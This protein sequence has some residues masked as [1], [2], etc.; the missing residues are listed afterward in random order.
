MEST[1]SQKKNPTP[2][3]KKQNSEVAKDDQAAEFFEDK[4]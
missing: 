1:T 2:K 4:D 3:L